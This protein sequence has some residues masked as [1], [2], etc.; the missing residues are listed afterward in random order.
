MPWPGLKRRPGGSSGGSSSGSLQQQCQSTVSFA[1]VIYW[2]CI[3]LASAGAVAVIVI[4]LN[5]PRNL[6]G[7]VAAAGAR[8]STL[9][10]G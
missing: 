8:E 7:L 4:C 6:Q 3:P 5:R 10:D 2:A 1:F 9:E